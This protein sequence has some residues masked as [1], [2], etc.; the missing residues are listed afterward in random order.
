MNNLFD[1]SIQFWRFFVFHNQKLRK[2]YLKF[3]EL[4]SINEACS[5]DCAAPLEPPENVSEDLGDIGEGKEC[6]G[7]SGYVFRF[8][9]KGQEHIGQ[10]GEIRANGITLFIWSDPIKV[11]LIVDKTKQID[12][13]GNNLAELEILLKKIENGKALLFLKELKEK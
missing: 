8:R 11:D 6:G 13:D 2:E 5:Q 9:V 7:S 4:R 3:Y 1:F 10:I 12:L